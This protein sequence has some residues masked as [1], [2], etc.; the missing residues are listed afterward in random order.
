MI[1]DITTPLNSETPVYPGDPPVRIDRLSDVAR[2]DEFTLSRISMSLHA[3][4]HVDAPSHFM[5][6]AANAD[7][8]GLDVLIGPAVLV[9]IPTAGPITPVVLDAL[10]LRPE[11]TRL[12]LRTPDSPRD[13]AL[14][15][16]AAE[17]LVQYG[18]K[19]VG[20][21]RQSIAI[22][23]QESQVHRT[24]LSAGVVI[25]ESLDLTAPPPGAYRLICL[26]MKITNAEAAPAR[27]V[28]VD[29]Q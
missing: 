17:Q 9:D 5:P 10:S 27:A 26:P 24:L 4:T 20:I 15:A 7:A 12:L 18:V 23:D 29:D 6:G 16:R 19:L 1:Y 11:T 3:G 28:L 8:I 13:T 14:D 22:A 25:V 21:D 2:G